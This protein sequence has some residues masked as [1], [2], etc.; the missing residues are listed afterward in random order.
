MKSQ[1]KGK[2]ATPSE[3]AASQQ[4]L[5]AKLAIEL[6]FNRLHELADVGLL[7]VELRLVHHDFL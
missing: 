6:L 5:W 7:L 1:R 2:A 3:D 4:G